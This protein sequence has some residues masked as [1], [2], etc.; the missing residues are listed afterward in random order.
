MQRRME[1]GIVVINAA[2]LETLRDACRELE[3]A[4]YAVRISEV[5]VA[6]A[7]SIGDKRHMAALNPVFV[8]TGEKN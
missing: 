5:S 8:I 1:G 4:G 2:T 6:R 7:K 3:K